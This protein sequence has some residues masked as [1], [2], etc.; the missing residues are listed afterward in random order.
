MVAGGSYHSGNLN[1][2]NFPY[3]FANKICLNK[4][5]QYKRQCVE[6]KV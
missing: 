2:S 4:V 1:S 3:K 5:L 6:Y